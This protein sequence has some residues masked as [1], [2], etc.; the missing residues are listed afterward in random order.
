M[1]KTLLS[2]GIGDPFASATYRVNA[3]GEHGRRMAAATSNEM[4]NTT[5][6]CSA[7]ASSNRH[8]LSIPLTYYSRLSH[9]D[10]RDVYVS[11]AHRPPALWAATILITCNARYT[12]VRKTR[13][14]L[15]C[16]FLK[17]ACENSFRNIRDPAEGHPCWAS[18]WLIADERKNYPN[19]FI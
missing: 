19:L 1:R 6:V 8:R 5:S 10:K 12:F 13:K 15:L 17:E 3:D 7:S 14:R 9:S 18:Y 16:S 11:Y 2:K 4:T